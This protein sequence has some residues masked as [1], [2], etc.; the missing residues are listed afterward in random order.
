MRT[1]MADVAQRAGTSVSTVSLVLN[2]KPGVS[3]EVREVVIEAAEELG[4]RLPERRSSKRTTPSK[5]ITVVHFADPVPGFQGEVGFLF[6]RYLDGIREYCEGRN[7]NWAFIANYA[8]RDD[9]PLGY[10]LLADETLPREGLILIGLSGGRDSW[11][12]RQL[13]A[14]DIP[15]VV[16]SRHWPDLPVS[17]VSQDHYQQARLAM[18]YLVALGHRK[19]AFLAGERDRHYDWFGWRLDCYRAVMQKLGGQVDEGL[20]VT[21]VDGTE[22]VK[23]LLERRR[24]V[25]AIWAIY[26]DRA[27]EAMHG[28]HELDLCVPH[29]VS[30]I[31]LDNTRT[32]PEGFPALSSVGFPHRKVGSLAA[33][34][35]LKQMADEEFRFAHM[36]VGSTLFER[37]SCAEPHC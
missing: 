33:E 15:T 4:Y 3:D 28:L 13:I 17:T 29:D 34:I 22:A 37:D 35:L 24:D 18:D 10:H 30:V 9:R 14:E 8:E 19:I 26:D 1:T 5:S 2:H 31:G 25:T 32:S 12:L 20:I 21:A 36:V 6:T 23:R 7:V 16:L 11:L 27:I